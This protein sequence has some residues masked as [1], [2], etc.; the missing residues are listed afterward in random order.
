MLSQKSNGLSVGMVELI[1]PHGGT[2]SNLY[3]EGRELENQRKLA[4]D[5]AV[6][7]LTQ[8]QLCDIELLLNGAFSPL[9]G[10]L[11][12]EDYTSVVDNMRLQ[13]GTLWPVP[14]TLDVSEQFAESIS[15]KSHIALC[16]PEG[17]LIANLEVSDIY[18][19]DKDQEAL[20]VYGTR[21]KK[22]PGV[23]YLFNQ[24]GAVYIGGKV[25]G[26]EAPNH[27]DY[28]HLRESPQEVRARFDK[29]GWSR[30]VAFHTDKPMHR[31]Q[32]SLTFRAAKKAEAN[33]LIQPVIGM[34]KVD[35]AEYF[36]RIR[37]Y[38]K[39]MKHYPE[40]TTAL[41]LV[42]LAQR[43]SGSREALWHAI[44]RKNYG[45]TH[46]LVTDYHSR[47]GKNID[48]FDFY[49]KESIQ[50]TVTK[51]QEEI[52]IEILAYESMVYVQEHAE[53]CPANEVEPSDTVLDISDEELHRRLQHGVE[54]P[55]WFSYPQ[56]IDELRKTSPPN[57]N[58]GFTVFFTGL[59]GAGK[60][61]IANALLC[62]LLELGGRP[63]TLLDG[64]VVRTNLSSELGFSQ[65]HRD[66]NIQ[67][68]GYVASEI[69]KNRGIA[70]CAPIAPYSATRDKVRSLISS[71]GGFLEIHVATR[72]E[73]CEKRDRKGLY[74]MARSGKIKGFTGVDD[75]YE[76]PEKPEMLIQTED[77]TPDEAA[78]RIL[79]KLE[80][81]G[82][83]H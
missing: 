49:T 14:V 52:G 37:C 55:S 54:I 71:L 19:P 38:E 3:V 29:L 77:C 4:Q 32:Q 7:T 83:I 17:V 82:Y 28:R 35:D 42:P 22:H 8:R 80:S 79:L 6:W 48:G 13:D 81:M 47:P 16:D 74:A 64:D 12:E 10:F 78:H 15:G 11:S 39:L 53:Y 67:R 57:H 43:M 73:T 40:Q 5:L 72:I 2:L 33:L 56:V 18:I 60:S 23:A 59:S 50:E 25:V 66:L 31:E 63:V 1:K 61:T 65:E 62:K 58:R 76:V 26:I 51:Y 20:Q 21:D 24:A 30:V 36:T 68:I 45:C 69:T 34:D 9:Q 27:Y 41:S 75:P 70:I 44:V 46:F